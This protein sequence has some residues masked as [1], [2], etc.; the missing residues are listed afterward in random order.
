MNN[1]KQW[2]E[3]AEEI[4]MKE[5]WARF[6]SL[7]KRE[8]DPRVDSLIQCVALDDQQGA[9]KIFDQIEKEGNK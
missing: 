1:H 7:V 3:Q 4:V 5:A 6:S 9:E 2:K 8:K